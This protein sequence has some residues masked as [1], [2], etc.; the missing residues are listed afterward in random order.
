MSD[1]FG[2]D[3]PFQSL[4]PV[5]GST[6]CGGCAQTRRKNVPTKYFLIGAGVFGGL[7]AGVLLGFVLF[8][9]SSSQVTESSEALP[10]STTAI[11]G[12]TTSSVTSISSFFPASQDEEL[13]MSLVNQVRQDNGTSNLTWCPALV[14]SSLAHSQDMAARNYFEHDSP[15]GGT[16]GDR[17]KEAGYQYRA[18]GENIAFGQRTVREVMEAWIDSPGHFKNLISPDYE[19]FGYAEFAG[20]L[21]GSSGKFWT[22]NFGAGGE[23]K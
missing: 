5:C 2:F 4:C 20:K 22:Q 21:D 13:M 15:D 11:E 12:A 10:T 1:P 18:V 3:D 23:C 14:R 6:S 9:G 19:H 16:I 7:I 8:G 17:A